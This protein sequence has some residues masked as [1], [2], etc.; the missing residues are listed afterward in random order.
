[1]PGK[2]LSLIYFNPRSPHGERLEKFRA[3][4]LLDLFQSTLP[5]RGATRPAV[6]IELI[7][8]FQSTLPARGATR[9]ASAREVHRAISIHAP[10]TGSDLLC[11]LCRRFVAISIHAPRTGS[12]AIFSAV[13]FSSSPFQST[14]P[15][16]GA[17]APFAGCATSRGYFNPRSPHGERHSRRAVAAPQAAIS[18]HAPRTGSDRAQ[19]VRA[20]G[21]LT[22]SIHAPRTGSDRR[23]GGWCPRR[24]RFQSTLPARG[25]TVLHSATCAQ[26]KISIHAPRT[27]SDHAQAVFHHF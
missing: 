7:T 13:A 25:A 1:M 23:R 27:G 9:S 15:A 5:A 2:M 3:Y 16:R 20:D 18:I 22:I 26:L 17:T 24:S 6:V 14:L 8:E 19:L 21:H 10:R 4:A 12:D 11:S